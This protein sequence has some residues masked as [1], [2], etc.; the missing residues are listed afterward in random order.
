MLALVKSG[1]LLERL[2]IPR[3]GNRKIH[4]KM[5]WVQITSRKG[6]P[7]SQDSRWNPQRL[8]ARFQPQFGLEK[9]QSGLH[10]DMQRVAE[11]TAPLH[12]S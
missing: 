5:R 2:S 3:Y 12:T 10:G 4:V 6:Q 8:Y 7:E 1:Y 11:M 9:I